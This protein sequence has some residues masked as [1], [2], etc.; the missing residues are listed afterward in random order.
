MATALG[1][2]A[3]VAL[4]KERADVNTDHSWSSPEDTLL[5]KL[6]DGVNQWIETY[7]GRVLSPITY[8]NVTFDGY[9]FPYG[10]VVRNGKGLKIRDGIRSVS[11]LETA[12]ATG[13][14]YTALATTDYVLWPSE[15]LRRP[16]LPARE[17]HLSNVGTLSCFPRG[18]ATI[19]LTGAG[20]PATCPDDVREV[21]LTIMQRAWKARQSGQTDEVQTLN[22]DGSVEVSRFVAWED[23]RTLRKYIPMLVEG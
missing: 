6:A 1:S 21:A 12:T 22:P 23:K 11:S 4:F 17:I 15:Q 13:E 2:Y 14:D 7:T 18:Y 10:S 20:G 5:G 9:D 19:R 8:T 16:N 3:T